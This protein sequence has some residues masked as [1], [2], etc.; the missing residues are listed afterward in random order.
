MALQKCKALHPRGVEIWTVTLQPVK[1]QAL[2]RDA[3]GHL[4]A[5]RHRLAG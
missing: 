3:R 5:G 1:A 4:S 2:E